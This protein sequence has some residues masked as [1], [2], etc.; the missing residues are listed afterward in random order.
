[1]NS[2]PNLAKIQTFVQFVVF[3]HTYHGYQGVGRIPDIV[4]DGVS[5]VVTEQL[6]NLTNIAIKNNLID[7]IFVNK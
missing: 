5:V 3:L 6:E 7:A 1:M 4:V 2:A